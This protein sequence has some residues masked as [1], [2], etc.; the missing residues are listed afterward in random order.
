[1]SCYGLLDA[2]RAMCAPSHRISSS[3]RCAFRLRRETSGASA[4]RQLR[5]SGICYSSDLAGVPPITTAA[6]NEILAFPVVGGGNNS[7]G[8]TEKKVADLKKLFDHRVEPD[9]SKVHEEAILLTAKHP[10]DYTIEQVSA[11]YSYLKSGDSSKSIDGWSYVPD[12]RGVNNFFWANET[13]SLGEKTNCAGAGDCGDFAILMSALVESIGGTTRIILV[14]NNSTGNHA[15]AE[16]YLGR[17]N[18]SNSQVDAIINW[19]K[20]QFDTDKIFVTINTSSKDVWLNLDWSADHPG[21]PFYQGYKQIVLYIR[22]NYPKFP[23]KSPEKTNKPPK[24]ISLTS[25]KPSPQDTGTAITWTAEAKDPENDQI[26]YTFFLND[27]PVT[28]WITDNKWVWTTTDSDVGENQIEVQVRDGKHAGPD[29]FDSNKIESFTISTK[30]AVVPVNVTK[31]TPPSTTPL[32]QP[33]ISIVLFQTRP[34]HKFSCDN[35]LD[36]RS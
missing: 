19:F 35:N 6:D 3:L 14:Q 2:L 15:Y 28:K 20:Q 17:L 33:P 5:S 11:I 22:E 25:D 29:R 13:L 30:Q 10:G 1:M 12:P 26:F 32:N 7:E 31:G 18:A 34:A 21:G 36:R 16:V 8:T 9:N 27:D 24:L 4:I 23:L